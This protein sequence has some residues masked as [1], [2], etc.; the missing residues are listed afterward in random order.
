MSWY[1]KYRPTKISE[2]ALDS[3]KSEFVKM[4]DKGSIPQVLLF[5]GPK[6]TGKTSSARIIASMLNDPQNEEVVDHFFFSKKSP[7]KLALVEP[8]HNQ[9]IVKRIHAGSSFV[10][11]E[12]DAA[13]NRG[14]DDIR[15]L[16]ERLS[17]PPQD[18]KIS[19]YIL[20][21]AHMLTKEAFNAL[22]KMLEETPS[23]VVFILATTELH[24][25]PDTVRSRC[26]LINFQKAS[27][28][29][30]SKVLE[31]IIKEEEIDI[32]DESKA[33]KLIAKV[34]DGSFR[35]AI[36]LLEMAVS[37]DKKVMFAQLQEKLRTVDR[38]LVLDLVEALLA[39]DDHLI[40]R[41]FQ[42]MRSMQVDERF[43][44]KSL[45][46]YLHEQLL[47]NISGNVKSEKLNSRICLF[48]LKELTTLEIANNLPVPLFSLEIKFLELIFRSKEKGGK[49]NPSKQASPAVKK[50]STFR[51]VQ[52]QVDEADLSSS[53]FE[54]DSLMSVS[55]GDGEKLLSAW[56][57][58]LGA[59]E[60]RQAAIA[61]LLRSSKP[62]K[63]LNGSLSIEVY[64]PF[65]KEKLEDAS[66]LN[67]LKD[68]SLALAGGSVDLEFVLSNKNSS[69]SSSSRLGRDQVGEVKG[70]EAN[71]VLLNLAEE[72]LV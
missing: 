11:Q 50:E 19:V 30:L 14:I 2:L 26:S 71:N 40:C 39:K 12:M 69:N 25:I 42:E 52:D 5:A 8:D 16:K 55:K 64:Y 13:S 37:T 44:F 34:A 18:G 53:D 33:L 72:V 17:L 21:E 45:L 38:S 61:M 54:S 15:A 65:H 27:Q 43:L 3:V 24:K 23:H 31:K 48:L 57:S 56:G 68:C 7:K 51:N 41:L 49:N 66:T 46:E 58:F 20:D 60:E 70:S 10:V 6:G 59:V 29:E 9:D 62:I 22:L 32:D 1:R 4:M 67:M 47:L 63:A 36:K 28:E 35:D